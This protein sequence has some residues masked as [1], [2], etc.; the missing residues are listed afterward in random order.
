[1]H[2]QAEVVDPSLA[3]LTLSARNTRLDC[4]SVT[5]FDISDIVTN[6]RYNSSCFMSQN[7]GGLDNK[8]SNSSMSPVVDIRPTNTNTV[9]AEKNLTRTW[10]RNIL[11]LQ[12]N[13]SSLVEDGSQV[14]SHDDY[15]QSSRS[16]TTTDYGCLRS[17]LGCFYKLEKLVFY[18]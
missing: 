7:H 9:H 6:L 5:N 18:A 2:V 8:V 10:F 13:V 12:T 1:M 3:V 16:D 17:T 4:N 14:V 11:L 15:S